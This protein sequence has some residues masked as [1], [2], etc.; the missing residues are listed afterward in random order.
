L[1][2][3]TILSRWKVADAYVRDSRLFLQIIRSNAGTQDPQLI[4][5][6]D[7]R[8]VRHLADIRRLWTDFWSTHG[9]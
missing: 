9:M 7:R 8:V 6:V 4:V 5:K 3:A 1:V 2:D